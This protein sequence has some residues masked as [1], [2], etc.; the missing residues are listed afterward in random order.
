[1]YHESKKWRVIAAATV[2]S[3]LL[4]I[5]TTTGSASPTDGLVAAYPFDGNADDVSGTTW[6]ADTPCVFWA[7]TAVTALVPKIPQPLI[8]QLIDGGLLIAPVGSGCV[9]ELVLAR[10]CGDKLQEMTICGCRFVK[11]VGKYGFDQ[12]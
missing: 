4:A 2:A 7:V 8:E 9:Q 5:L 3:G 11:L 10:K 1:M 12:G 6:T